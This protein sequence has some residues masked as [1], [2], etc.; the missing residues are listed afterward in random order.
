MPERIYACMC[1]HVEIDSRGAMRL[2]CM[3]VLGVRA[4][5]LVFVLG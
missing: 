5:V 3:Y 1:A 4:A 2:C